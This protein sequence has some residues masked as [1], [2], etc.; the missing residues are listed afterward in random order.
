MN[1]EI[2]SLCSQ[3]KWHEAIAF[4]S[5]IKPG[6]QSG[7]GEALIY[8]GNELMLALPE[9]ALRDPLLVRI[10]EGLL[11]LGDMEHSGRFVVALQS[12]IQ[13]DKFAKSIEA[14]MRRRQDVAE[15][16]EGK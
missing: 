14:A 2:K 6:P 7:K 15:G 8:I 11:Q 10:V 4:V 1:S 5:R 16:G 13:Q 3:R 12:R 9:S